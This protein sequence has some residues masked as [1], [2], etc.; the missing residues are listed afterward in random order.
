MTKY[1]TDIK[2]KKNLC[3]HPPLSFDNTDMY[4]YV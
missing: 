2:P 1:G 4:A 3:S